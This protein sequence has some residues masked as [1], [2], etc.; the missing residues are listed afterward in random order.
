VADPM[1][2]RLNL[3]QEGA[4][5]PAASVTLR[6]TGRR[7]RLTIEHPGDLQEGHLIASLDGRTA[8][9]GR[10]LDLLLSEHFDQNP[11]GSLFTCGIEGV[12]EG[13]PHLLR[14]AG[15]LPGGVGHGAPGRLVPLSAPR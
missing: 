11:E 7:V 9:G 8:R 14:W 6:R 12:R 1:A 13:T 15:G 10:T 2:R 5:E 3:L 4:G